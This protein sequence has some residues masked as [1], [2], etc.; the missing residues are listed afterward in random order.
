MRSL[1]KATAALVVW[2]LTAGFG[3]AT[4]ADTAKQIVESSGIK[5]GYCV[6]LGCGDGKLSAELARD[7][8]M[9][10][11]G[12]TTDPA[13]VA[14]ARKHIESQGLYG[15][16]TIDLL[17]LPRLPYAENLIDLV[18]IE[19][20][21]G[22]SKK[23]LNIKEFVRVLCP[24]GIAYLASPGKGVSGETL[25]ADLEKA[26][27][28]DFRLIESAGTW[29]RIKKLRPE[30]MDVWTHVHRAADG[31]PVSLDPMDVPTALRWQ[32]K[33]HYRIRGWCSV[34]GRIF[35]SY[36]YAVHPKHG[37]YKSVMGACLEA[38]NAYNG[39]LLWRNDS[40]PSKIGSFFQ[41]RAMVYD[42][43][44][45]FIADEKYVYRPGGSKIIALDAATG[46]K[47][48]EF[49][50]Y[51]V[52]ARGKGCSLLHDAGILYVVRD[53]SR[54]IRA[55]DR[56]TG[57]LLWQFN[58]EG[59]IPFKRGDHGKEWTV[60]AAGGRV[61]YLDDIKKTVNCVDVKSD[62]LLWEKDISAL[63]MN[64]L[65]LLFV[66][67]SV[68]TLY[69][70]PGLF[71]IHT[72]A[73]A[74]G[75][76][77]WT[78]QAK[79]NRSGHHN[80]CLYPH[81]FLADGLVWIKETAG[82]MNMLG[83]DPMSGEVKRSIIPKNRVAKR[84][85]SFHCFPHTATERFYIT[86]IPSDFLNLKTG[87]VKEF[88][89]AINTCRYGFIPAN[90]LVYTPSQGGYSG[91]GEILGWNAYAPREKG[92]PEFMKPDD[93]SRLEEGP[94]YGK[95]PTQNPQSEIR[96]PK[97]EWPT[98]RHDAMRSGG[99]ASD[100]PTGL[101]PRWSKRFFKEGELNGLDRNRDAITA[102]VVAG[103]MVFVGLI[104]HHAVVALDA[105]SGSERWRFTAG[106]RIDVPPTYHKGFCY[107][108]SADG[109]AYCLRASD[110]VL[111]WR[112][113]AAA[114]D[115]RVPVRGQLES[116]WPVLGGVLIDNDTVHFTAGRT[117]TLPPG[118]T[119]Y[120]LDSSTGALKWWSRPKPNPKKPYSGV[121]GDLMVKSGEIISVSGSVEGQINLK[122]G[123]SIN[124]KGLSSRMLMSYPFGRVGLKK[125]ISAY[126]GLL[127]HRNQY[128]GGVFGHRVVWNPVDE[129]VAYAIHRKMSRHMP[130]MHKDAVGLVA[131][132]TNLKTGIALDPGWKD[133]SHQRITVKDA[134]LWK[135]PEPEGRRLS[136]LLLAGNTLV[137]VC[138][139]DSFDRTNGD[140]RLISAQNGKEQQLLTLEDAP[141]HEGLAAAYGRLYVTTR[142]GQVHCFG[143]M[144]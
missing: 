116:E 65:E 28:K 112:F 106:G 85:T 144:D 68:L 51:K 139:Q 63:P 143:K 43:W 103:G 45:P 22:L 125:G 97:S 35:Y 47:A 105:D 136:A 76:T 90:G 16:A 67:N 121:K 54:Q 118:L 81:T 113:F 56:E 102:P 83:C 109:R 78:Y 108:G 110:G 59:K 20:W 40:G 55:I 133:L 33:D 72:I 36:R 46:K 122:S 23:G 96:N 2:A 66:K 15:Q 100:L 117:T 58:M 60:L 101:K 18:V 89:A 1:M 10:V 74:D 21:A 120:A 93:P 142:Q 37:D 12:L 14:P 30:S 87:E 5:T 70:G 91:G 34:G 134:P 77:L 3:L 92:A 61:Y 8:A 132:K 131:V 53:T 27:L 86:S 138:P 119:T 44:R 25:K 104:D 19:D 99:T 111:T 71:K 126:T 98:Y 141:A 57:K 80:N 38:R 73:A 7:G 140:I 124:D 88:R 94:A 69:E 9:I 95:A 11:H 31:N 114:L 50:T 123:A 39:R 130:T 4:E 135:V 32:V 6:H 62:K 79:S 64:K 127:N 48:R 52:Y 26:G 24:E 128:F 17:E 42:E 29:T 49:D 84:Y 41:F 115:R 82:G 129:S 13:K 137:A 75:K 107:F